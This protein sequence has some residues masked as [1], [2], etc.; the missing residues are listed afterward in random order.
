VL[1]YGIEL[2]EEFLAE[3]AKRNWIPPTLTDEECGQLEECV[4]ESVRR[5]AAPG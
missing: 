4:R 2:P 1:H 3:A 5:L